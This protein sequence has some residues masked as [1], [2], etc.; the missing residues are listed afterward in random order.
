MKVDRHSA[1]SDASLHLRQWSP[2]W[3]SDG[4]LG[5]GS[6]R[7]PESPAAWDIDQLAD[8]LASMLDA[9]RTEE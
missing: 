2:A 6:V 8:T 7:A 9:E 4:C 1:G 5:V 3:T